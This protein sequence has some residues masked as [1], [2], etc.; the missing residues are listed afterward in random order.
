[1]LFTGAAIY[2]NKHEMIVISSVM[3][4]VRATTIA[5]TTFESNLHLQLMDINKALRCDTGAS[6]ARRKRWK[7]PDNRLDWVYCMSSDTD[8]S[9]LPTVTFIDW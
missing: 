5:L 6:N 8:V 9:P 7:P 2:E 1:V 3:F 4:H